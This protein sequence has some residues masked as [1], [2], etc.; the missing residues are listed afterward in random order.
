VS[1]RPTTAASSVGIG[2]GP[3]RGMTAVSEAAGSGPTPPTFALEAL[4]GFTHYP[5]VIVSTQ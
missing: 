4:K 5:A 1:N 2:D 3:N